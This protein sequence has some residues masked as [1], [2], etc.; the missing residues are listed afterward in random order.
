MG[1]RLHLDLVSWT[2]WK[3]SLQADHPLSQ[4]IWFLC[5]ESRLLTSNRVNTASNPWIV[6]LLSSCG[7]DPSEKL[8]E[9]LTSSW[10]IKVAFLQFRY[11]YT[12]YSTGV[13]LL[14]LYLYFSFWMGNSSSLRWFLYHSD[15]PDWQISRCYQIASWSKHPFIFSARFLWCLQELFSFYTRTHVASSKGPIS[16][17][18]FSAASSFPSF[19]LS[20]SVHYWVNICS[21]SYKKLEIWLISY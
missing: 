19:F 9:V 2:S 17:F 4:R 1:F 12:G 7:P 20:H 3:S 11:L 13:Y 21:W 14:E 15:L 8:P 6:F 16:N 18:R 10:C 5:L